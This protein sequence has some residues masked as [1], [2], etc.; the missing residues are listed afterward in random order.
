MDKKMSREKFNAM[1]VSRAVVNNALPAISLTTP[2]FMM[3]SAVSNIFGMGGTSVISCSMGQQ[4]GDYAKRGCSFCMWTAV[5]IGIILAIIFFVFAKPIL[6]V[7]G[8][9]KDTLSLANCCA[10]E[11]DRVFSHFWN[12]VSVKERR[13]V[14]MKP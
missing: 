9:S 2:L 12:T 10:L 14:T 7:L 6:N 4:C 11:S 5:G 13:N 3:F 1:P 8:A